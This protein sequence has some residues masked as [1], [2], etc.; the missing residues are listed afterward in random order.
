MNLNLSSLSALEPPWIMR[1]TANLDDPTVTEEFLADTGFTVR[2][3]NGARMRTKAQLLAEFAS[4]LEFPEYFGHNW[5]ALAD[6][7]GDLGWL[8]GF[9]YVFLVESA[10]ELLADEPPDLLRLFSELIGRV[11]AAWAEPTSLGEDW[12]RVAVPF[13][14]VLVDPSQSR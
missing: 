9:A 11:A 1:T 6:C 8:R 14:L 7:L 3:L 10:D 5:D 2:V 12:D 13:H 4:R